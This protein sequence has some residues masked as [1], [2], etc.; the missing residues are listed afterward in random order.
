MIYPKQKSRKKR[1]TH[2]GSIMQQKDGRCYLCMKL[3]GDERIHTV[4]HEHHAFGGPNRDKSEAEGL[5]VFLCPQHHVYGRSA[6]HNNHDNML[7]V[8]QD[9]Q[10][11]YEKTHTREEFM[12][13]M[14]RNYLVNTGDCAGAKGEE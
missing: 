5:K 9:C 7:L 8:Q 6:V 2:K 1:K 14:G 11:E 10:R 12:Q 3:W 4:I 13:L